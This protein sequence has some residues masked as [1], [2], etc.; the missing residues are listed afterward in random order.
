MIFLV[1]V[2]E[3]VRVQNQNDFKVKNYLKKYNK[4]KSRSK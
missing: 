1:L 2:I 4:L 3:E